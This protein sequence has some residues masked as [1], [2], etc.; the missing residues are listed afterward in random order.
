[1]VQRVRAQAS[2]PNARDDRIVC[3][4]LCNLNVYLIIRL[5]EVDIV[6]EGLC[7]ETA[8][9]FGLANRRHEAIREAQA[10]SLQVLAIVTLHEQVRQLKRVIL[11]ED[12]QVAFFWPLKA[13]FS[14]VRMRAKHL[15][16]LEGVKTDQ[17]WSPLLE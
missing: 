9:S 8:V 4:L 16:A 5:L 13:Q 2:Q 15:S 14:G 1:M 10:D 17:D 3:R 11:V 6:R 7:H 12:R